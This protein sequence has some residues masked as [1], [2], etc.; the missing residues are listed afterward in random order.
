[1][2]DI[3]DLAS[4]ARDVVRASEVADQP[5]RLEDTET[6]EA[7]EIGGE[8]EFPQYGQFLDAVAIDADGEELGPRWVEVPGGLA[9]ELVNAEISTG[10]CFQVE[11]ASKGNDDAWTFEIEEYDA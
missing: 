4:T 5:Y 9:R 3:E 10:D 11:D 8:D 7:A 6:T 1:M 2:T